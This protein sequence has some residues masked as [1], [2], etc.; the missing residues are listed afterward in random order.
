M[1]FYATTNIQEP[2]KLDFWHG[3]KNT[4]W[5]IFLVR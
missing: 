4:V 2:V 3:K 5:E 1:I